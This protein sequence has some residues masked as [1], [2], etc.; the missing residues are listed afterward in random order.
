MI[1]NFKCKETEKIFNREWSAK[2]PPEI[3]GRAKVKLL[4]INFASII[5][6]LR[7]PPSN[8]LEKLRGSKKEQY[9]IRINHQWR[10]CLE[11]HQNNAYNV[12]IIDYH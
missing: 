11:W 8:H 4:A 12:E 2:F 5:C 9:S 7:A 3:Q 1:V 6:E 10:I